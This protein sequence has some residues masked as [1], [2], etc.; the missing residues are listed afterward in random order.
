[1]YD[2]SLPAIRVRATARGRLVTALG[3]FLQRTVNLLA[4]PG[5]FF[6]WQ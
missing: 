3:D 5:V 1:V 6:P 4:T 2:G